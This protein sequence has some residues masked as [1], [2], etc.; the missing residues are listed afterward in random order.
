MTTNMTNMSC[1]D[2]SVDGVVMQ[3]ALLLQCRDE[4]LLAL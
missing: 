4:R 2:G 1:I 3:Q